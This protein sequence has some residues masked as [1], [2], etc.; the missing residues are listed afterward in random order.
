[1]LDTDGLL[2]M[3]T[4]LLLKVLTDS[5]APQLLRSSAVLCLSKFMVVSEVRCFPHP[6]PTKYNSHGKLYQPLCERHLPLLLTVLRDAQE[7]SVRANIVIALGDLALRFP[8]SVEPFTA[9]VYRPL[10]DP[11]PSVRKNTLMVLTHL[12]LNDMIKIRGEV[13]E[14]ALRLEDEDS[15]V[16]DLARL[17]FTE[18]AKRGTN[19]IYNLLPDV[20][21][22]LSRED[23]SVL[24]PI[25]FR[26]VAKYLLA[27]VD[28]EK[29]CES[30]ADKLCQRIHGAAGFPGEGDVVVASQLPAIQQCR[31]LAFCLEHLL[32]GDTL[33]R[34]MTDDLF[35]LY[36]ALLGDN[37]VY[38]YV[39]S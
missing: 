37:E 17:F 15:R 29:Q 33:A 34:R 36:R 25:R 18:L 38:T 39:Y 20:L 14:I 16:Q 22:G 3:Y 32:V 13:S 30:I 28:K 26:T 35:K 21:G 9:Q 5:N 8:N 6:A 24:G 31:D 7:P 2:G 1:M 10:R 11:M 4:P 27:F 19:P 23:A 12:V